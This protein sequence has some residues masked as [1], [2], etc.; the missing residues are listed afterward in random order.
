MT[1]AR[2]RAVLEVKVTKAIAPGT[3]FMP[4]HWGFLWADNAEVNALTHPEACPISLEPELKACAV[5]VVAIAPPSTRDLGAIQEQP[6]RG[7]PSV[8]G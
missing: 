4:M 2:G 5:N 1:S 7:I 3:V 8:V 6:R